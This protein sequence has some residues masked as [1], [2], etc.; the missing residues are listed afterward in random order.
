M[1]LIEA[2]FHSGQIGWWC[3]LCARWLTGQ[4]FHI[5]WNTTVKNFINYTC[6]YLWSVWLSWKISDPT[7]QLALFFFSFFERTFLDAVNSTTRANPFTPPM[8][9]WSLSENERFTSTQLFFYNYFKAL[10]FINGDNTSPLSR[11]VQKC[12]GKLPG[13]G[14]LVLVIW[15]QSSN[16]WAVKFPWWLPADTLPT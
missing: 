8:H 4:F 11:T 3:C 13:H 5:K 1:T 10:T 7:L 2:P 6:V 9:D 16:D 14:R 12:E 15:T